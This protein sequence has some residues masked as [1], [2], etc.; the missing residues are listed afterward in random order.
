MEMPEYYK[1]LYINSKNILF[2][3]QWNSKDK[4]SYLELSKQ[5]LRV[6]Y[7]GP[8]KND[9]DAASIRA[10]H[11]ISSS[12]GLYYYEVTILNKGREGFIG[13][14]FSTSSASLNVLPG[15]D[16]GSWGFHADDGNIFN[17][18]G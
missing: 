4:Y 6:L 17:S 1:D 8:G 14:G 2:P 7:N 10:D 5:N 16:T 11:G 9:S 18:T 15:W 12:C 13:I 3:T